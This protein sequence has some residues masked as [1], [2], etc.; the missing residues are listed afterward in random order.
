MDTLQMTGVTRGPS[1]LRAGLRQLK[2]KIL[3]VDGHPAN[4]GGH[5]GTE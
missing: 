5:S 3:F 2:A 1:N 4:D